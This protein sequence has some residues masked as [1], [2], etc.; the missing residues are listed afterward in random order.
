MLKE[1]AAYYYGTLGKGCGEAILL[2]ANDV[3]DL[4]LSEEA[5]QLFAGFRT[6]MGCGSTCGGLSGAIGVLSRMYGQREDFKDLCAAFVKAFEEKLGCGSADCTPIAA[7]Y[8]TEEARCVAAVELGAQALEDFI[9]KTEGREKPV[10][11]AEGCTLTADQIKA[12]KAQGFLHQK[13]TN[14]FNGRIITRNGRITEAEARAIAD[15]AKRYG[16]GYVMMTTRLTMEVSGI[17]FEKTEAFRTDMAKAGLQVGGT[18]SKVRPVVS[19]KGTTCQYGLCDTYDVSQEIHDRF[20]VG[21]HGVSLPHKFKIAVG[22]CP[23]NC[24]KPNLNDVG[25]VGARAPHYD[26]EA[27]RGCK[28][29]QMELSCPIKAAKLVDKKLVIDW[30]ACNNCGR[31]VGKCPF[32][33]NDESVYGYKVYLGGRWGKEVAHGQMLDKLFTTKEEAL[34]V[35]EKALLLFRAEGKSGERFADTIQRIGFDRAQELLLSNELLERKAEILG[36]NVVGGA[37]C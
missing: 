26:M 37:T 7:K 10:A 4:K 36:L 5:I 12:V 9:D 8:K 25:I 28:K 21:Y 22:G 18:G 32:H 6:G 13:G 30:E 31:C 11:P 3:Y 29:C 23:N 33:C 19:C 34:D 20:F 24:V 2:A 15:A 16:D 17:P 27:C 1:K 14:K 35:V